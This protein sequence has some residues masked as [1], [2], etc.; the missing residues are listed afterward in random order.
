MM[1]NKNKRNNVFTILK[2]LGIDVKN[3]K[4]FL[5]AITHTSYANEHKVEALG[6]V[7]SYERLEFLGDAI[8]DFL[9]G[10]YLYLTYKDMP[11]GE[12]TKIRSKYVCTPANAEYAIALKLDECLRLGKGE[13][14]QGGKKKPTVLADVFEAFLGAIYLDSGIDNVRKVMEK[15]VFDKIE[16]VD[17]G[18]FMDYKSKLQEDI[19]AESRK[20]IEYHLE[21]EEGPS[22]NKI[23]TVSVYHDGMKL[24]T[25]IGKSKKIA[26]QLA[27]KDALDKKV[28]N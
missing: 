3:E 20:V 19:Q 15:V 18:Y 28:T 2:E 11:E 9:V 16:Y 10:E 4:L 5:N 13:R 7:E 8:L 12:L 23:F 27:A 26:E 24:G 22:H 25:G 1:E 14:V 6:K 21:S 17:E